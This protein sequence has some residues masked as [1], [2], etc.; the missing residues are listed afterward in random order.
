M[1]YLASYRSCPPG[2]EKFYDHCYLAQ[3][4]LLSWEDAR[5]SCLGKGSDLAS[6]A[7]EGEQGE[8]FS[9]LHSGPAC[10]D[11]FVLDDA[12]KRCYKFVEE[13]LSW[14]AAFNVC[15][16]ADSHL[17]RVNNNGVNKRVQQFVSGDMEI[18]LGISDSQ[19]EG[20]WVYSNNAK[21]GNWNNW[22]E[23]NPDGG[24]E[25]N[26]ATMKED[27]KWNDKNCTIMLPFVCTK[28]KGEKLEKEKWDHIKVTTLLNFR[29]RPSRQM[30][31]LE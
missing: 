21:V 20:T 13:S 6:I 29:I 23:G 24:E 17:A 5:T 30:D 3:D 11:G 8:L 14:G 16:E 2:W 9:L 31:W 7:D 27:G 15:S 25:E 18:W 22:G 28:P 1:Y 12:T 10:P 26:C 4:E 19:D